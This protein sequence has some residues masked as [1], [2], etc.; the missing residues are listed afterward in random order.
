MEG[1]NRRVKTEQ[2]D[3]VRCTNYLLQ[4][5]EKYGAEVMDESKEAK[6][7]SKSA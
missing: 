3:K 6:R 1:K 2:E 7:T 4:M 5:I